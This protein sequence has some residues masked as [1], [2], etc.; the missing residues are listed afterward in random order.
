MADCGTRW[1][2][3]A[4]TA[5]E[6]HNAIRRNKLVWQPEQEL[7]DRDT[8]SSGNTR[9]LAV[10]TFIYVMKNV[11]VCRLPV[12]AKEW[13]MPGQRCIAYDLACRQGMLAV[14]ELVE[15]MGGGSEDMHVWEG[16]NDRTFLNVSL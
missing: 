15:D 12:Q 5:L 16:P 13:H 3:T 8:K 10:N 11:M 7:V 2:F 6:S 4:T 9:G 1:A 14:V